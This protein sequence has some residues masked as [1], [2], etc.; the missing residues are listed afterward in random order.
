METITVVNIKCGG[1]ETGIR[2]KLE[3]ADMPDFVQGTAIVLI[4]AG[5]LSLS[6]MGFAGLGA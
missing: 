2:E 3:V 6:F 4:M 5:I 1:C